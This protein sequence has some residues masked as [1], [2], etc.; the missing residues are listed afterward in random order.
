MTSGRVITDMAKAIEEAVCV[1]R[2][3]LLKA[4]KMVW[5]FIKAERMGKL[6]KNILKVWQWLILIS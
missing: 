3:Q 6:L 5:R 1:C 4:Y 2:L